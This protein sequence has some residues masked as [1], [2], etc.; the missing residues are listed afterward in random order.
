MVLNARGIPRSQPERGQPRVSDACSLSSTLADIPV[1]YVIVTDPS[2]LQHDTAPP[3]VCLQD[4]VR[5]KLL[6][7][8]QICPLPK[9][10]LPAASVTLSSD[11]RCGGSSRSGRPPLNALQKSRQTGFSNDSTGR[12]QEFPQCLS[13]ARFSGNIISSIQIIGVIPRKHYLLKMQII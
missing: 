2:C 9:L 1:W 7:S 13:W 4:Q 5:G 11:R 3:G 8:N 12:V 6:F 10:G